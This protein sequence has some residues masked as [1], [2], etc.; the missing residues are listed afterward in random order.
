MPA[1]LPR[2]QVTMSDGLHFVYSMEE[3][4]GH[5][6][7]DDELQRKNFEETLASIPEN[8]ITEEAKIFKPSRLHFV[9]LYDE[10]SFEGLVNRLSAFSLRVQIIR[11]PMEN[12]SVSKKRMEIFRPMLHYT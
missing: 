12:F 3:L 10:S 9:E 5:K 7:T 11:L 2:F 6:K 8:E 4:Q 1:S